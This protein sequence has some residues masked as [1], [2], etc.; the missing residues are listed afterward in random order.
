MTLGT[1]FVGGD[2]WWIK[3]QRDGDV[4]HAKAWKDG[5][6]EPGSF[7]F[8]VTDTT[9]MTGRLGVRSIAATG[10]TNIPYNVLVDDYQMLSGSWTNPPVVSHTTW[11]RTLPQ[12]FDGNFTDVIKDLVSNWSSSASRAMARSLPTVLA[13]SSLTSTTTSVW[14]GRSPTGSSERSLTA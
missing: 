13:S 12:A 3:T 6:P 1:G 8:S 5:N 2:S 7:L 10:N 9:F 4:I 14:T 11:V